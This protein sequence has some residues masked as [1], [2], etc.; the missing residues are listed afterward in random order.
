MGMSKPSRPA[1]GL[2]GAGYGAAPRSKNM[3]V[4]ISTGSLS[5]LIV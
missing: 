3:G 4:N 2:R 5:Q 1:G